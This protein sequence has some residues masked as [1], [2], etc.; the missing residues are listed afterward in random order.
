MTRSAKL[1][2]KTT[3]TDIKISLDLDGSGQADISTGVGFFDH[4]L[5][6]WARHGLFDLTVKAQGDLGVDGHH[7]VEDIGIV[8]GQV[9]AQA[10]GDKS[11]IKRYGTSF[12]PMDEALAMVV[13]DISNR[14][15]LQY[16]VTAPDAQVG[17][18]ASE[19]TEEFMRALSANAGLTLHVRLMY[20]K[21]THH[22]TE[23]IFKALARALGEAVRKDDR[24]VGVLSTKGIL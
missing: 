17:D 23:A 5:T 12:V 13:V 21:N 15:Y 2:R 11:G 10:L 20:G 8:L 24:I 6:L 22:I 7:T 14:P 9:F 3:E 4:M 1:E 16:D 19:L 18:Y